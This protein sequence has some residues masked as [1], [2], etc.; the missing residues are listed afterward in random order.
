MVGLKTGSAGFLSLSFDPFE[1]HLGSSFWPL[2]AFDAPSP[3]S[4]GAAM[5]LPLVGLLFSS[6]HAGARQ[7]HGKN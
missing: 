5:P 7:W 4:I 6:D 2:G 3:S 1:C